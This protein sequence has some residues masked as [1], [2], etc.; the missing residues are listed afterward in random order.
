MM[1]VMMMIFILTGSHPN[2]QAVQI[3]AKKGTDFLHHSLQA[4]LGFIAIQDKQISYG[5]FSTKPQ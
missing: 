1:R 5:G 4:K 2:E 3:E